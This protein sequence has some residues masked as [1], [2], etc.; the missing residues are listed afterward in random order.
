MKEVF[1]WDDKCWK[2]NKIEY[3]DFFKRYESWAFF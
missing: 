1:L 2:E 3:D